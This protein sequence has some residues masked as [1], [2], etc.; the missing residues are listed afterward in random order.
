MIAMDDLGA[1]FRRIDRLEALLQEASALPLLVGLTPLVS[2]L[3]LGAYVPVF[4]T[5]AMLLFAG[6][7]LNLA[8]NPAYFANMGTGELRWNVISHVTNG[9]LNLGFGVLLGMLFGGVGVVVGLE[10]GRLVLAVGVGESGEECFDGDVEVFRAPTGELNARIAAERQL[11]VTFITW[12]DVVGNET[13]S[14]TFAASV[15]GVPEEDARRAVSGNLCR[16]ESAREN[17]RHLPGGRGGRKRHAL[18]LA[19]RGIRA[20][21]HGEPAAERGQGRRPDFGGG[22]GRRAQANRPPHH[23]ALAWRPLRRNGRTGTR[24]AR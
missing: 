18:R 20:D 13:A 14:A 16:A 15:H 11:P 1:R 10:H 9:V 23:L 4:V 21:R 22:K 8:A 17:L 5:F 19:V 6:W 2:R 7:F 24:R 12:R 3:W